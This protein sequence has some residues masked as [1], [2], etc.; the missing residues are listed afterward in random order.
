MNVIKSDL[1]ELLDEKEILVACKYAD[2]DI[3]LAPMKRNSK[4]YMKY[5]KNFGRLDKKSQLVRKMMPKIACDLYLKGD[6]EYITAMSGALSSLKRLFK[7]ACEKYEEIDLE[8]INEYDTEKLFWLYEVISKDSLSD[9]SYDLYIVFLKL[10]GLKLSDQVLLELETRISNMIE[11]RKRQSDH[12][13]EIESL[14]KKQEKELT[15]QFEQEKDRYIK[16]IKNHSK[17]ISRLRKENEEITLALEEC[18]KKESFEHTQI[19][20]TWNKEAEREYQRKCK[21]QDQ[22]L[23]Q[24]YREE[25]SVIRNK[26]QEEKRQQEE[27]L[28]AEIE[29]IRAKNQEETERLIDEISSLE[30]KKNQIEQN[31]DSLQLELEEL[32]DMLNRQKEIEEEFFENIEKRVY[33]KKIDETLTKRLRFETGSEEQTVTKR[34]SSEHSIFQDIYVK[35]HVLDT[36]ETIVCDP[37]SE[38]S[39]FE[40]DLRDNIDLFFEEAMDISISCVAALVLGKSIIVEQSIAYDLAKCISAVTSASM[41]S[42][43]RIHDSVTVKM[44]DVIEQINSQKNRTV[45]IDGVLDKFDETLFAAICSECSEKHL[46]FSISDISNLS[47]CSKTI[48][49]Y[50]VVFDI[51]EFYTYESNDQ[52]LTAE[53]D[54]TVYREEIDFAK[55]RK[56]YDKTF[57]NLVAKKIFGK[58]SAIDFSKVLYTYYALMGSEQMGEV[59]KKCI[60]NCCNIGD[61][62]EIEKILI[63]AGLKE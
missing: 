62:Q 46:I 22:K 50:S 40:N 34:M 20:E 21:E 30:D 3:F 8:K 59:M 19:V 9:L 58:K 47:L 18:K 51:E 56:Y 48:H 55:C 57:R 16:E 33:E 63:R 42:C 61:D 41:P 1:L 38:M 5:S 43:V 44:T 13:K 10:Y 53:T 37:V 26:L 32:Q 17:E 29:E 7:S 4:K 60:L 35:E 49:N 39:D 6:D 54:I 28:A 52:L 2:L 11:Q 24:L 14:L 15:S 45:L 36:N 31:N 27:K 25:L 12:V 23:A